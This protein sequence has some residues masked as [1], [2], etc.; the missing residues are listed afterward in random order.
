MKDLENYYSVM[1][2]HELTPKSMS[3][4][5]GM[6]EVEKVELFQKDAIRGR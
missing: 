5:G 4:Y 3:D 2:H 6:L 1:A